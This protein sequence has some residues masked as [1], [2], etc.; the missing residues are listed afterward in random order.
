M[1]EYILSTSSGVNTCMA[2]FLF[3]YMVIFFLLLL[4]IMLL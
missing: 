4:M 3:A 2:K 1:S